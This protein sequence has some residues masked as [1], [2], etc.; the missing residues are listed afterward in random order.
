[1][2]RFL[3][4][5]A[6]MPMVSFLSLLYV[7]TQ[8]LV[9]DFFGSEEAWKCSRVSSLFPGTSMSLAGLLVVVGAML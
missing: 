4:L 6:C 1:M 5:R 2:I 8:T 3:M 9:L 7:V